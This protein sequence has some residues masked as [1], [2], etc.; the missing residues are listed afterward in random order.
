MWPVGIGQFEVTE[1]DLNV[2][3]LSVN[4]VMWIETQDGAGSPIIG[5]GIYN[6]DGTASG[7]EGNDADG[8]DSSFYLLEFEGTDFNVRN[9]RTIPDSPEVGDKVIL[10]VELVNSGIPGVADLEIRSV[11]NNG[12][13]AFEG[14][15]VSEVIGEN[16]ARWVAIELAE[17]TDATT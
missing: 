11:I 9:I 13:P 6:D 10:E 2:P 16:Q 4:L 17:F 14:Y 12:V 1:S 7:I 8:S 3:G 15:I 5:A